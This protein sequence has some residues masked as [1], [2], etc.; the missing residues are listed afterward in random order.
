MFLLI[1]GIT[2]VGL[3]ATS[4]QTR[5]RLGIKFK[6]I[7]QGKLRDEDEAEA[8]AAGAVARLGVEAIRHPAAPRIV[9]PTAAAK[10]TDRTR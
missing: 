6:I 8:K 7:S 9:A 1:P 5:S 2:N 3:K 4:L 10:H